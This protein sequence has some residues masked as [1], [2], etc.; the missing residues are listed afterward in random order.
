[1]GGG[2]GGG[3]VV[4]EGGWWWWLVGWLVRGAFSSD[5]VL[6]RG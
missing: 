3:G 5:L 6:R 4:V 1:M 2:G